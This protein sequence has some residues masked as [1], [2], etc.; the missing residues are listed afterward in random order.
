MTV[1][2]QFKKSLKSESFTDDRFYELVNLITK[3]MDI[4]TDNQ[5]EELKGGSASLAL[6]RRK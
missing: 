6:Q 3:Q 4:Q 2:T 5:M 1:L